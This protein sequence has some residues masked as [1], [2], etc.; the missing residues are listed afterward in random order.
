MRRQRACERSVLQASYQQNKN[1]WHDKH[2]E[3]TSQKSI[4]HYC[5]DNAD[6]HNHVRLLTAKK[7]W[8]HSSELRVSD[9]HI[10]P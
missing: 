4:K 3:R 2:N 6:E 9:M 1:G 8:C 7:Q 5:I 10:V